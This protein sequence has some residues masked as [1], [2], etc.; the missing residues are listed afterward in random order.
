MGWTESEPIGAPVSR[1]DVEAEAKALIDA[2]VAAAK[3][4]HEEVV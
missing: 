1:G 3:A 2:K 4:G